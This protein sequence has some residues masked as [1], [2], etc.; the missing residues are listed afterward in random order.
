MGIALEY[1]FL[2]AIAG[3]L[4]AIYLAYFLES[5]EDEQMQNRREAR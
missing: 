2:V 4:A 3:G 1:A 5:I